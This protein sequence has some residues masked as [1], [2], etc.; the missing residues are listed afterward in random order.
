MSSAILSKEYISFFKNL[1]K[2]NNTV[3]FNQNKKQYEQF[4]KEPFIQVIENFIASVQ[5]KD[6]AI[7]MTAK[8][9]LFR[10]NRDTRFSTDKSPYKLS[11]SAAISAGGK[12]PAFP[13]IYIEANHNGITLICGAYAVEKENL[14]KI[15]TAIANDIKEFDKIINKK[16][17]IVLWGVVQGEKSKQIPG[18]LK[19]A[20]IITP[21]IFNKQFYCKA[22]LPVATITDAKL[23]KTLLE[24]YFAATDFNQ[25]LIKVQGL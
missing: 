24:Y 18:S 3:W 13:G 14:H 10:I 7:K 11:M 1:E 4:V 12:N 5:Q 17:F 6:S 20:A 15:R 22:V 8:E 19:E 9:A 21:L 23:V 2:N 25:F 16:K